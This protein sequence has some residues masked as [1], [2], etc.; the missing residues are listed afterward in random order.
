ARLGPGRLHHC[1]RLI[2]A[3]ERGMQLMAQRAL[4]RKAFGKLIA[5]H[6]SFI[7][8][9]AKCRVELE[10]TRL[11]V[12]EAADQLDRYGNKKARG[13]IAMAKVAAPN[14]A[15]Q[16]LD[17]AMQVHGAAGLSSDTVLAHLWATARTLRIADGPDEVHLG[18]IGKLELELQRAK[19]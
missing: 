2:G 17:M 3:A 16:V 15:L 10:K 9:L 1:M 14:M 7:S 6:G 8:D 11:L 4:N 12:L 18:T 13:I 5:Q 19:L